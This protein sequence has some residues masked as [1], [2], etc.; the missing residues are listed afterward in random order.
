MPPEPSRPNRPGL[1][2]GRRRVLVR[3]LRCRSKVEIAV[4]WPGGIHVVGE[5]EICALHE[6]LK[7]SPTAV[8]AIL[9]A[10]SRL[11][12]PGESNLRRT[13]KRRGD[14]NRCETLLMA[15]HG[16]IERMR[17]A[18]VAGNPFD[19]EVTP[20]RYSADK[21]PEETLLAG[22]GCMQTV[23]SDASAATTVE[24]TQMPVSLQSPVI[25]RMLRAGR[26]TTLAVSMVLLPSIAS[27]APK[28]DV[29]VLTNGDLITGEIR[30]L[31]FGQLKL[32]TDHL[33][34][35]YID[36][37]KI[38]SLQTTQLLQV[39][40]ASGERIFGAA[41]ELASTPGAI[42]L[43]STRPGAEPTPL[44]VAIADVV[45][46]DRVKGGSA[47]Y[48]HLEGSV[49]LGYSYTPASGV[50]VAS[51]SG[52]IGGR[53]RVRHWTIELDAQNTSQS[54]GPPSQR[55]SLTTSW[56]RFL[57]NR[58][59]N[60]TT[61][62]FSRNEELGLDLRSLVGD[63]FGRYLVQRQGVEWRVG[64]GLAASKETGSDSSVRKSL[65][66]QLT[67]DLTVFRFDHPKTNVTA[68]LDFLPSITETGR[69]RGEASLKV[70]QE[71]I[72]DL[73]FQVAFSDSYD[74]KA[75]GETRTNDWNVVTSL[76]YS[77]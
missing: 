60:E 59:Y 49:N 58:H 13:L 12:R 2:S 57:P 52:S 36:W 21:L 48:Q 33:G 55:A 72:N 40:L 70:N 31:Q 35:I 11:H 41:P 1:V 65:E 9:D 64:A 66:G 24:V 39:E 69:R 50:E 37:T 46:V 27:T 15:G 7:H 20:H 71:L 18:P 38:A 56:E 6:Q 32:K 16:A 8:G 61:L 43:M 22:G 76:G 73:Y 5:R 34:T 4:R 30:Q 67:T 53:D 14:S 42:R 26:A 25:G 17:Q 19:R 45:E 62:E 75:A 29:I 74:N 47:W 23:T 54:S 28:T 44:E 68:S 3:P 77:F 10:A 63:T 51:F